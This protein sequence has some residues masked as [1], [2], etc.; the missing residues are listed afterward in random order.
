MIYD[1][2]DHVKQELQKLLNPEVSVIELGTFKVMAIFR[3]GKSYMIVGG[4]VESGKLKKDAKIRV[5]RGAEIIGVGKLPQLQ[6]AKQ[7]VNE[8]AEGTECGL[9]FEGKLELEVGDVL[10]V[11]KEER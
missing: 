5:R 2:F 11:Y 3:T 7:E 6:T 4:R 8:V 1:L 10:E 9:K